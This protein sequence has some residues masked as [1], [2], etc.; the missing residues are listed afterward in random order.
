MRSHA[1][2]KSI[3]FAFMP[4]RKMKKYFL[5]RFSISNTFF[6]NFTHPRSHDQRRSAK[7]ASSVIRPCMRKLKTHAKP[8]EAPPNY[9]IAHYN[10]LP[11][12]RGYCNPWN[13]SGFYV[14]I[15]Y[16]YIYIYMYVLLTMFVYICGRALFVQVDPSIYVTPITTIPPSVQWGSKRYI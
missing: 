11:H 7:V 15:P 1:S 10:G 12:A 5:R 6:E 16:I 4:H 13:I 3:L 14:Y 9:K 2:M 8:T